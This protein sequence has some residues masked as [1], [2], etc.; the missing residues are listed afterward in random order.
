MDGR[1]IIKRIS[2]IEIEKFLLFAPE[3]FE[4][5][6]E[7]LFNELPTCLCK[8]LGVYRV[9]KRQGPGGTS[10][11]AAGG[12]KEDVI[13]MENL[14]Y[15]RNIAQTFDLKGSVRNRLVKKAGENAVLL[16]ENLLEYEMSPLV[17][18]EH[19][20]YPLMMSL[21]ND[22]LFLSNMNVMDYS[23][24]V[25]LDEDRQELVV[26]VIDY[27]RRYT[28]DKQLETWVKSSGLL[29]GKGKDPTVISPVQYKKRFREAMD[30]YF[31]MVPNKFTGINPQ[32]ALPS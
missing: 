16:D 6:A 28:W 11:G 7:A 21:W 4:Y 9:G 1:Y 13:V 2:K 20:K 18:Q 14:F 19:S 26:G 32:Q 15:D 22:T 3:Y 30:K 10:G 17:V 29:G 12:W 23:L 5:L 25:G 24:L 27:V 31:M 8:I